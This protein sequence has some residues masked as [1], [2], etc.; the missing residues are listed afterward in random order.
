MTRA[1]APSTMQLPEWA[2]HEDPD[3]DLV[4]AAA[5]LNLATGIDPVSVAMRIV[6]PLS[7]TVA[8]DGLRAIAAEMDLADRV[9]A[10]TMRSEFEELTGVHSRSLSLIDDVE[11]HVSTIRADFAV[12]AER[13][14]ERARRQVAA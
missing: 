6:E 14:V 3:V 7:I 9:E 5:W 12:Q 8:V 2:R 1:P 11:A 4:L 10:C 13:L